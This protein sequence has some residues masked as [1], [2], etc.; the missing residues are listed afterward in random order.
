MPGL[1]DLARAGARV[2]RHLDRARAVGGGYARGDAVTRLDRD[3]E[4]SLE[5]GLVLGGHQVEP[6]LLAALGR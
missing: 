5:G 2:D 1:H 4:G 6:Q 3:R